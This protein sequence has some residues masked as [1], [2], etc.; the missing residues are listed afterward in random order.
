MGQ[1]REGAQRR[2]DGERGVAVRRPTRSLAERARGLAAHSASPGAIGWR[3]G[4][5]KEGGVA[6]GSPGRRRPGAS[7]LPERRA[8][9][10]FAMRSSSEWKVTTAS[11]PPGAST[12]SAAASPATSSPSSSLTAM[13]SAWKVR[14]A[15]WISVGLCGTTRAIISASGRVVR[16][17][18]AARS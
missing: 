15:G 10:D 18:V 13:R 14:V 3:L 11:R 8:K 12:R 6:A 4:K 5:V 7:P 16:N 1:E 9:N 17:G 2:L